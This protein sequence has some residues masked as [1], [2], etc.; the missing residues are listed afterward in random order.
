RRLPLVEGAKEVAALLECQL[1]CRTFTQV[2]IGIVEDFDTA[3][4]LPG[5]A[6][7]RPAGAVAFERS[8][9][10]ARAQ[11]VSFFD[12]HGFCSR[13]IAFN[14]PERGGSRRAAADYHDIGSARR[15]GWIGDEFLCGHEILEK[16]LSAFYQ[17]WTWLAARS[18][19][20]SPACPAKFIQRNI[21]MYN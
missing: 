18:E 15:I 9:R 21:C 16:K 12:Q 5:E 19:H 13:R 17:N 1:L 7:R 20:K 3:L 4:H 6:N 11:P 10:T 14:C 8:Q 2:F